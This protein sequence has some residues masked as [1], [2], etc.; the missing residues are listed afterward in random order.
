MAR[1]KNASHIYE[2]ADL[3]QQRCLKTQT[4]L[5]WPDRKAWSPA[6]ITSLWDAYM[7]NL[8]KGDDSFLQKWSVQLANCSPDVHRVAADA[9]TFYLLFP[10]SIKPQNKL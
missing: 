6:N 5:L 4:S 10:S 3:F 9:F 7:G 8:D 2:V 1:L